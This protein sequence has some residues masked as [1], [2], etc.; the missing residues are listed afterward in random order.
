MIC[1]I[2]FFLDNYPWFLNI[3]NKEAIQFVR[4][5]ESPLA[6]EPNNTFFIK[7]PKI[8][9]TSNILKTS[10]NFDYSKIKEHQ[11]FGQPTHKKKIL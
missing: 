11:V 3:C 4:P 1:L 8:K 2:F 6:L 5:E 10:I 7:E 9:N